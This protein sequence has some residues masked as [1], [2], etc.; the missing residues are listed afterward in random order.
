MNLSDKGA[1]F[2]GLKEGWVSHWYEDP[3]G[4]GTIGHGFTW[5]STSFRAWWAKNK[6]GQK[7]GPGATMTRKEGISAL[8]YLIDNEYGKAVSSFLGRKVPQHVF[9]G[10]V[11]PVF[12]LGTGALKWKWAAACKAGDY[13]AAAKYLKTTGTTSK[14]VKLPGLVIRRKEEAAMIKDGIYPGV[15][16]APAQRQ[17]VDAMADGILKRGEAGPAVY[18]L[19]ERLIALG[20]YGGRK[21]DIF[22]PGTEAAVME[23]QREHGLAVDGYA[24]PVT[25][26]AIEAAQKPALKPQTPPKQTQNPLA[27][28]IRALVDYFTGRS[29]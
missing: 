12:N 25:L 24:G 28:L 2:L 23:F 22:G 14:G 29:K 8:Q 16:S 13:A 5:G 10:M 26:A 15:T 3:T 20:Y 18:A 4:T 9:D 17:P 19:I 11:S 6:P 27:A 7:F 1:A 21:D